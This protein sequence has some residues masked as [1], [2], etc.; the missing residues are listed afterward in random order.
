MI[1]PDVDDI[2]AA[3]VPYPLELVETYRRAGLWNT[4]TVAQELQASVDAFG[5]KPA[6]IVPS[7]A[8]RPT[9]S[10]QGW[11]PWGSG[12]VSGCCFR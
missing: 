4:R 1:N 10:R 9:G 8:R 5:A 12:P 3:V 11:S 2:A 6:V 7:W